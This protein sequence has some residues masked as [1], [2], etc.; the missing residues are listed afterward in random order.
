MTRLFLLTE[1][2]A[3]KMKRGRRSEKLFVVLYY[4]PTAGRCV[5]WQEICRRR[6]KSLRD[7]YQREKKR[8]REERERER[9]ERRERESSGRAARSTEE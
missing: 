7:A 4:E 5:S 9:R 2:V 8:E 6:W 3:I 1:T